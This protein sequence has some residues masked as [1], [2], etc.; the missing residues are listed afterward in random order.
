MQRHLIVVNPAAGRGAGGKSIPLIREGLDRAGIAY[1][2]VCTERPWHAAEL[3]QQAATDGYYAVVAA[4][5]DGTANEVINGLMQASG[6]KG[7]STAMG[8]LSV[9][10]GNDFAFGAGIPKPLEEGIR[11]LAEDHKVRI[12]VGRV[13]G[14]LFPEGRFF[15]NGVG[16][17]FDAVVGFEA[18][19]MR[20]L[21][22]FVSYIAAALKTVWLY[23]QGPLVR[24]AFDAQAPE[25]S[26]PVLMVSIMNGRRMGGGFMMAPD[27]RPTD[28]VFD[29]CVVRQVKRGRVLGLIPHFMRGT[30][31]GQSEIT[32]HT[33]RRLVVT[34]ERGVLPAHAD[35]ETLCTDG[36]ELELELIP[37]S[38]DVITAGPVG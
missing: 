4:G 7:G 11:T 13:S 8:A 12:D 28:G 38:L 30:Q 2:L 27:G 19:K 15:G 9:G 17:G 5:G 14:G 16:I 23:D 22:G 34:A 36:K 21:S 1:D 3:A 35:G 20:R 37:Q 29:V 32:M 33:P 25:A 31:V 6:G 24:L 26:L 18:V 10:R